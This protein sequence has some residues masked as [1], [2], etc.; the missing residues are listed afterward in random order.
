MGRGMC[1]TV[2]VSGG[3]DDIYRLEEHFQVL[4][5]GQE[6]GVSQEGLPSLG[7]VGDGTPGNASA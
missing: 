7:A 2:A 1:Q 6:A 5:V 3:A 4:A